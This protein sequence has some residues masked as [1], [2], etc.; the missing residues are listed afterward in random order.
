[1][2][3]DAAIIGAGANG[4]TAAAV[5]SRAGLKT[6]VIERAGRI[7]GRLATDMFHPG[8]AA[9]PFA[10]RVP[11]IPATILTALG[12]APLKVASLPQD[13]R[14]RRDG[15]LAHIFEDARRPRRHGLLANT[16]PS[17]FRDHFRDIGHFRD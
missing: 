12:L 1:M 5:L 3:Y 2:R 8:F 10:D 16:W 6:L 15:A 14:A 17:S 9:S 4:L 13:A 7:G 11:E